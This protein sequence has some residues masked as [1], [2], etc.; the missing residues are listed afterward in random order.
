[1]RTCCRG[2]PHL[3]L[4]PRPALFASCLQL[5]EVLAAFGLA[6]EEGNLLTRCGRCNGEFIPEPLPA[7]ALPA[8][9]GV[10]PGILE[11]HAEFWVCARCSAVFW[12]GGQ[13]SRA[14]RQGE[15]LVAKMAAMRLAPA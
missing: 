9:H 12:Q 1:M 6:V 3:L 11:R 4:L 7:A 2:V 14:R 13:F 15:A 5:E 8:G 10:P